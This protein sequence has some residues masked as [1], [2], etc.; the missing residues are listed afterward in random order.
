LQFCQGFV[1]SRNNF[2]VLALA[3]SEKEQ[4]HIYE[5][6]VANWTDLTTQLSQIMAV[7]LFF[8]NGSMLSLS[9]Q[10]NTKSIETEIIQ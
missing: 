8:S 7:P 4:E 5:L 2:L 1:H 10:V 3:C 9:L 6:T